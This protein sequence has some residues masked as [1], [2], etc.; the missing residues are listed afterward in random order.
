MF[1]EKFNG[2]IRERVMEVEDKLEWLT[3]Q[4]G[5][6]EKRIEETNLRARGYSLA[7]SQSAFES[8]NKPHYKVGD[9]IKQGVIKDVQTVQIGGG[10]DTDCTKWEYY[11]FIITHDLQTERVSEKDLLLLDKK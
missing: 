8:I 6:I 7:L 5:L 1:N 2:K 9:K 11:Y 10:D 3:T 4:I